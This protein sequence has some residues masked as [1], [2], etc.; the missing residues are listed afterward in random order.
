MTAV[1]L[2]IPTA[3]RGVGHLR[4]DE[5]VPGRRPRR[6]CAT[7]SCAPTSATPPRPSAASGP[8]S[9]ARC[10]T[11]RQLRE[12]GR[13][14]KAATMARLDEH[15]VAAGGAGHRPRRHGA[16]GPRRRTRPTRSS[17]G[18]CRPPAPTRSS[19]S[20]RW[21][22][23]RSASTRRSR[24]PASTAYE[25]DLAELIVQLGRRQAV[26]HPGAGDPPEPGRDPRDLP[27]R[28]C[29]DVDPALT[30]EP[31]RAGDGRPRAPARAVPARPG[32]DQ[33]GE[34]RRRRD[35]HAGRRRVRG[36]RPDVPDPAADADHRHGHREGAC[37]PGATSRC[38]CSCCPA[39]RPASG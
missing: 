6:R 30:D 9:S 22:P 15:L 28:R 3:P 21:P 7:A 2:G 8:R 29:P 32:R 11:G 18:W 13:A 4:G 1:F 36:Q 35:R 24:P 27:A 16:L 10:P 26:A 34:L 25:T 23:R 37:R 12:A 39:P 33:R 20:S 5:S 14:I 17:P 19:R 31:R 38:S